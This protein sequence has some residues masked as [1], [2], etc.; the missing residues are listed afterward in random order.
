MRSDM[1][2]KERL[3]R[4]ISKVGDL[5][6]MPEIVAEVLRLTADPKVGMMQVSEAIQRDPAM[7][8]KILRVSNSAYYGMK[9]YVGTLKL[10]LVILGVR[11]VRN[12][13]LGISV[14]DSLRSDRTEE[15]LT[16]QFWTHS[17]M[18][19][20]LAKQLG[21]H[22][23]LG[24][25]GEDFISGLLH[26]I[27]KMVMCRQ[28]GRAYGDVYRAAQGVSDLLYTKEGEHFG[29]NHAEAGAALAAHWNLPETLADA[30]WLHHPQNGASL[31]NAK[32]PKLAAVVRLANRAAHDDFSGTGPYDSA[33]CRDDEAWQELDSRAVLSCPEVRAEVLAGFVRDLTASQVPIE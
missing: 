15:V 4:V 32:D 16:G 9:Q 6:A 29:F 12:I 17:L 7:T 26:D 23:D 11:E 8:A 30:L 24:L 20:A 5:P 21:G 2:S 31:R 25:Q 10:A 3:E 18:V 14:F 22:L 1:N 13:V 27:G 28:L 19:A 33:A